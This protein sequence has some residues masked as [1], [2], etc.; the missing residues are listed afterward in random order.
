MARK[1]T[2]PISPPPPGSREARLLAAAPPGVAVKISH[3][4][5]KATKRTPST[6]AELLKLIRI[7]LADIDACNSVGVG[8]SF[9]YQ[10][11]QD[12]LEFAEEIMR[13]RGEAVAALHAKVAIAGSED[14]RASA[15]LL[16]RRYPERYAERRIIDG[17]NGQCPL[18]RFFPADPE[19]AEDGGAPSDLLDDD[20]HE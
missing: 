15:W 10:W 14:W 16:S 12:D 2:K 11:I 3:G 5:G 9:F 19:Q 4:R 17:G 8:T 1:P 13:A 7:G 18:D 6:R 20:G